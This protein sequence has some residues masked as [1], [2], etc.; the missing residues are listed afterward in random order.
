LPD[1]LL[2]DFRGTLQSDGYAVYDHFGKKTGVVL[3]GCLAH[4]RREFER[5]LANDAPRAT[6]VLAKIQRL[7]A[8]EREAR[9]QNLS[10]DE[11]LA[12]RLEFSRPIFDELR[13]FL[14]AE[15]PKTLPKTAIGT[16]IAYFLNRREK[17]ERFL[18]DGRLEIDNNLVE[19]A[20][21]PVALGRKNY[22]FAGN[23]AAAQRI[24]V[25]YSLMACC[26]LNEIN[27]HFWLRDVLFR[28]PD[29]PINRIHELLP[30]QW[31]LLDDYPD[32]WT[33]D[34]FPVPFQT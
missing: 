13:H 4:A 17:L 31:K 25:L 11:R 16:A 2:D 28:L 12:R 8:V 32:W 1:K 14:E 30:G 33:E 22:L 19:N 29:H 20:I 24:A 7:Y 21:R 3:A 26:K 23:H 9:E 5:A 18:L 10:P 15:R 34:S 6:W 27:P